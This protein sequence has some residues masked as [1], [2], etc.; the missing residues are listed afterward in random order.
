MTGNTQTS[1]PR[2]KLTYFD[3]DGGRGEAARLTLAIGGIEFEDRRIPP[4]AWADHKAQMPFHALPVL[5]VDGEEITQS[6][7]INRYLGKLANLY[8]ADPWQAA[9]CDEIMDAIE[10]IGTQIVAT[11]SI[12]DDAEK[13]TARERL[14]EGPISLYL[15]RLD[16]ELER[17]GGEYFADNRLTVADLKVFL[18][19]RHLRSGQLDYI[20]PDL[21][22][23]MAPLLVRHF[24]RLNSDL[25][26]R[27]YYEKR[28]LFQVP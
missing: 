23:R 19:I 11:F 15:A 8:P 6:N 17:R 20:P 13:K 22:D 3:F 9:L 2:L 16:S 5:E 14:A 27:A 26:I 1:L 12:K 10:D 7:T 28:R 4:E 21:P 25:R 18:W 24:E